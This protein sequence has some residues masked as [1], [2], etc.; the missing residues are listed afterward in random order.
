MESPDPVS[1]V[2]PP[3]TTIAQTSAA[4]AISHHP[5][6]ADGARRVQVGASIDIVVRFI[7]V[8]RD[9]SPSSI[10]VHKP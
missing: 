8:R 3:T 7:V 9:A 4:Q 5:T 10:F 1:L 2:T 6:A